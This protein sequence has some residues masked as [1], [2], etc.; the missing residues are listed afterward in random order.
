MA[1]LNPS[2][3]LLTMTFREY[4]ADKNGYEAAKSY[5]L[6]EAMQPGSTGWE[7]VYPK[8][9]ISSGNLRGLTDPSIG[10]AANETLYLQWTDDNG[11]AMANANDVLL[12]VLYLPTLDQFEV[13]KNVEIRQDGSAD[14]GY[15]SYYIGLEAHC[16]ACFGSANGAK[17]AVSTYLGV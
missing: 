11:H 5:H 6:T 10:V 15:P 17:Y 16:W 14:I 12:V 8:V 7:M 3:P 2:A 9:L 13:F 4:P 1:F